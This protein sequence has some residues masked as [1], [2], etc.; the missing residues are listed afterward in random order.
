M[1]SRQGR[2]V[3]YFAFQGEI[4]QRK[5]VCP[6]PRLEWDQ[7]SSKAGTVLGRR[8]TIQSAHHHCPRAYEPALA[9]LD[10]NKPRGLLCQGW[11][12]LSLPCKFVNL[13]ISF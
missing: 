3:R 11:D 4:G 9:G 1:P 12:L 13:G 6:E 2:S 5:E 7:T 8:S 10:A